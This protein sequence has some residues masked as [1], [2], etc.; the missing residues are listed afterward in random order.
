MSRLEYRKK[1]KKRK[2]L[3]PTQTDAYLSESAYHQD[4]I[5]PDLGLV[6]C[7]FQVSENALICG[8]LPRAQRQSDITNHP[9]RRYDLFLTSKSA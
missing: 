6:T 8:D 1:R 9:T 3:I 2:V 4:D 5:I 7:H